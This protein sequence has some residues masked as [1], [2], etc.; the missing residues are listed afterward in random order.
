MLDAPFLFRITKPLMYAVPIV[1]FLYIRAMVYNEVGLRRKDWM[2]LLPVLLNYLEMAPFYLMDIGEKKKLLTRF[3]ADMNSGLRHDEGMLPPYLH[4]VLIFCWGILLYARSLHLLV[5]VRQ[6]TNRFREARNRIQ[7]RWLCFF[8]GINILHLLILLAHML[9]FR[10]VPVNTYLWNTAEASLILLSIGTAL[11]F[12]P[13]ILY[14]F[15]G[16]ALQVEASQLTQ[17][18]AGIDTKE[19]RSFVISESKRQAYLQ[20]IRTLL[21]TEKVFLKQGYTLKTFAAAADIPYTYLSLLINQEYGMNFNELINRYRVDHVKELLQSPAARQFTLE[22]LAAQAGFSSRATFARA[23][24]RF[25]GCTPSD[26][27]KDLER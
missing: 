17:L 10:Q 6:D 8:L 27:L 13:G 18:P 19:T 5:R 23:F 21:E 1:V 16:E 24:Q 22:A 7:F 3:Y 4:P 12:L 11:F 25:A 2:L 26:F 15:K 9:I 14:G 20:Q